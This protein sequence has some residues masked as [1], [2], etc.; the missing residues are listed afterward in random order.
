MTKK[1]MAIDPK[2]WIIKKH[3]VGLD[4]QR[5]GVKHNEFMVMGYVNSTDSYLTA[6]VLVAGLTREECEKWIKGF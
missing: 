6:P 4:I 5:T 3:I 2:V 1:I